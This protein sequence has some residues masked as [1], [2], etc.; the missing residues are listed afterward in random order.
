MKM[1]RLLKKGSLKTQMLA[2]VC[3]SGMVMLALVFFSY[4]REKQN[5]TAMISASVQQHLLQ[6]KVHIDYQ[7]KEL[8]TLSHTIA[9]DLDILNALK[10][11]Q[12]NKEGR[13]VSLDEYYILR[14]RIEMYSVIYKKF[15][16][17][18]YLDDSIFIASEGSYFFPSSILEG[19]SWY[20][21][22]VCQNGGISWVDHSLTEDDKQ[23]DY[24]SM[25]R[26]LKDPYKNEP[27]G[28][29]QIG[30]PLE[31]ATNA[32]CASGENGLFDI[33]LVAE[34]NR[35]LFTTSEDRESA[36]EFQWREQSD[37]GICQQVGLEYGGFKLIGYVPYEMILRQ[38]TISFFT[39][40]VFLLVAFGAIIVMMQSLS[41]SI[42]H[43]LNALGNHLDQVGKGELEELIS[44]ECEDEIGRLEKHL[45]Q[46]SLR[47]RELIS[48]V[49][50]MEIKRMET[51]MVTLQEQIKPHFLYNILDSINWMAWEGDTKG[52]S[53]VVTA[54][55]KFYRL[56]L[57]GGQEIVTFRNET[58]IIRQYICLQQIRYKDVFDAEYALAEDAMECATPKML[59][60]PIVENAIKHGILPNKHLRRGKIIIRAWVL[61]GMLYVSV[62]DNGGALLGAKESKQEK[63]ERQ[64]GYGLSSIQKRLAL[65]YAD[66][67]SFSIFVNADG[68]TEVNLSWPVTRID[69]QE[70]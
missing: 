18:I 2:V 25:V 52:I 6:E 53:E 60:Q 48:E 67:H 38:T 46:M 36:E 43:R 8:E 41:N 40:L 56:S 35:I 28:I 66:E 49:Y 26:M 24:I 21:D 50:D 44:I 37:D 22:M 33:Y 58:E 61:D 1:K 68:E 15:K 69:E 20:N 51:Q 12:S 30:I 64:E 11:A 42:I 3:V 70:E 62:I 13:I 16:P 19:E 63:A 10:D 31:D 29:L 7:M 45:N 39:N 27:I 23:T 32:L 55:G 5:T 4:W 47:I 34:D 54:L 57:S 17:R 59:L 9:S 14:P 65:L